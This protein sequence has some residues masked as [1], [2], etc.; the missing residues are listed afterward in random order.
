MRRIAALA[1][2]TLGLLLAAPGTA[3][4]QQNRSA[5]RPVSGSLMEV[6]PVARTVVLGG[7]TYH[8]PA[9]VFDLSRL[10]PGSSIILHWKQR[11]SRMVATE[12]EAS[13]SEG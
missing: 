10:A 13:A 9:D 1:A 3:H 8:V 5:P 2:A 6:D 12:I 4:A 7:E 11:G